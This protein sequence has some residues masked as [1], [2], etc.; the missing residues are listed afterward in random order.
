M[1]RQLCRKEDGLAL[2]LALASTFNMDRGV[3]GSGMDAAWMDAANSA[4][5]K[6]ESRTAA[7]SATGSKGGVTTVETESG[8]WV[9]FSED[10]SATFGLSLTLL[11]LLRNLLDTGLSCGGVINDDAHDE[12]H[13]DEDALS[14][15]GEIAFN[16]VGVALECDD[17]VALS[18]MM[19]YACSAGDVNCGFCC[20]TSASTEEVEGPTSWLC[21]YASCEIGA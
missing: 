16:V 15:E 8:A 19:T 11:P 7:D 9:G 1:D 13:E 6:D 17:V 12:W 4:D 20:C 5:R 10:A 18:G 21:L 3:G 14:A 2:V